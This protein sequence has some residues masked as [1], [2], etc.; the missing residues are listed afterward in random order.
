MYS[1]TY[2]ESVIL[3]LFTKMKNSPIKFEHTNSR[4]KYFGV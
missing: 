3:D 4:G 1:Y 2:I